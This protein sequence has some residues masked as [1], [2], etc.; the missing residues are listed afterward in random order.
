MKNVENLGKEN[1]LKP[2]IRWFLKKTKFS[3]GGSN[4]KGRNA[5]Y[6]YKPRRMDVCDRHGN[7]QDGT[8]R[9]QDDT[10]KPGSFGGPSYDILVK[11]HWFSLETEQESGGIL[12]KSD[13]NRFVTSTRQIWKWRAAKSKPWR[14]FTGDVSNR[15]CRG[16]RGG[17]FSLETEHFWKA[18]RGFCR[19]AL[20]RNCKM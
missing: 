5:P 8:H 18:G 13:E 16:G 12:S 7:G 1:D 4:F 9:R 19:E 2:V 3:L 15:N 11:K 17:H 20:S 6:W 14:V 10:K